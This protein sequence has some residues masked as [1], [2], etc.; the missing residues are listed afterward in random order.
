MQDKQYCDAQIQFKRYMS[1]ITDARS[2]IK[3]RYQDPPHR[4][5]TN[6]VYHFDRNCEQQLIILKKRVNGFYSTNIS[7][8][9]VP[10]SAQASDPEFVSA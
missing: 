3:D 2:K 7:Q 8:S 6:Q 1:R 5:N 9:E 10:P 4:Q